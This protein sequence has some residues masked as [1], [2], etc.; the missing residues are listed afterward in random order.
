MV[1]K[2]GKNGETGEGLA[3]SFN[4]WFGYQSWPRTRG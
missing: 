3:I 1:L 2:L 4:V